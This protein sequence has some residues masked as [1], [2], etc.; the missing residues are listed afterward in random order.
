LRGKNSVKINP[1]HFEEIGLKE[2]EKKGKQF[3]QLGA[4]SLKMPFK[5]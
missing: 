3:W 4:W 1:V 2:I 5:R